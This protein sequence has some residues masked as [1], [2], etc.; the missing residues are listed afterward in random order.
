MNET[1]SVWWLAALPVIV[2]VTKLLDLIGGWFWRATGLAKEQDNARLDS[3]KD[4]KAEMANAMSTL[5]QHVD[6]T[7]EKTAKHLGLIEDRLAEQYQDHMEFR[8]KVA[9]KLATR[10]ELGQTEKRLKD[11]MDDKFD[12]LIDRLPR[13]R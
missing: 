1:P 12:M 8:E 5:R 13:R 3:L 10:E 7:N 2:A 6:D 11:H 4:H 9:E